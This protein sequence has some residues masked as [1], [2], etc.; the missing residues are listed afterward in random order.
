MEVGETLQQAAIREVWEET[1][2]K[3][4]KLIFNR[5]HEIIMR[6]LAGEVER[7]FVLAMFVGRSDAGV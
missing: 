3:L 1:Q 4:D 2:L 7:H 6:D 5:T